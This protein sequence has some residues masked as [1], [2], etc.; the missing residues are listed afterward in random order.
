MKK[1]AA[2]IVAVMFFAGT[3]PT[4]A[5]DEGKNGPNPNKE[6]Y[7]HANEHAKFKRTENMKDKEA[8]KAEKEAKR[9]SEKAK[10]EERKVK[11]GAEKKRRQ[12]EKEAKKK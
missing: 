8:I 9:E 2:W 5:L 1:M 10:R 6:A 12:A 11:R 3:I 7:E 4:F